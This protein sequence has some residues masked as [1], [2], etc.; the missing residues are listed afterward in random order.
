M[1]AKTTPVVFALW[2]LALL[3]SRSGYTQSFE[4]LP[5]GGVRDAGSHWVFPKAVG[6]FQRV[7]EPA[8]VPQTLH[9]SYAQYEWVRAGVRSTATVY[10]YPTESNA[11]DRSL[12]GARQEV[13]NTLKSELL[14]QL[15]SEGPFRVGNVPALVGEKS[16]YKVG[17]GPASWQTN[18]YY[19][20]TGHWIVKFRVTAQVS[21]KDTFQRFDAFVRDQQWAS[22]GLSADTCTG[23]ACKTERPLFT[24]GALPEQLSL[25]LVK[26]RLKDVVPKKAD[27]CEPDMV[28]AALSAAA[29]AAA[30]ETA[31]IKVVTSC[32]PA[33]DRR[34]SF[35][36]LDLSEGIR[37]T[38]QNEGTDGVSLRGPLTFVVMSLGRGSIFTQLHDGPLDAESVA[39]ILEGL[40]GA[41]HVVFGSG[42]KVGQNPQW[43]D[44]L[45][46]NLD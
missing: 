31:D 38:F 11:E 13:Q 30:T 8:R 21:E 12:A 6:D 46:A 14:V 35:V 15:W 7:G 2:S 1:N 27:D 10:V 3:A 32:A 44:R 42:N 29:P 39:R 26:A 36:R 17:L 40:A 24:H 34:A 37:K 16:F 19:F 25:M 4:S 20:D 9:D 45:S 18:L 5:D 41:K 22:L 28:L 23:P 33:K 43:R